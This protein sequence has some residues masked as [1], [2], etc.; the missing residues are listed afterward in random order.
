MALLVM[1]IR[2]M[3]KNKWLELSLLLGLVLSVGLIS[4]MPIYTDAILQ[5]MLVK[6]MENLQKSSGSY[7]G[8]V[9]MNGYTYSEKDPVQQLKQVDGFLE[10]DGL[11]YFKLPIRYLVK[12]RATETYPMILADPSRGDTKVNYAGEIVALEG[13]SEH[14]RLVDGRLPAKEPVDGVYEVLAFENTLNTFKTVIGTELLLGEEKSDTKPERKIKI[15]PVGVIDVKDPNDPYWY[16]VGAY[17]N[18]LFVDYSLFEKDFTTSKALPVRSATWY[19]VLDY[20]EMD[21]QAVSRFLAGSDRIENYLGTHLEPYNFKVPAYKTLTTYFD[22]EANLRKMLWSLNVPVIIMLAFYLF[23]VSNLITE[24]QKTEIAVLRSRG[25]SRFQVMLG[26]LIEGLLLG[27]LAYAI[28]PFFG[29]SLTKVL[30]SSNGF[31]EFVQ[32]S[33]LKVELNK[34]AYK[35]ALYAVCTSLVMTLIPAFLATRTSIVGHKQQLARQMR[36]SFWHKYGIDLVLIGVSI[37]GLRS[38]ERQRKDFIALGVDGAN[39]SVDP[40]LFLVP[41][42]FILGMGLLILRIYPW[43]VRFVYWL[44][45]KWWPPSLYSTLIQVGRSSTQYQFLMVFLIMTIATGLY[46]ASAARTLNKNTDDKIMY[47][48]GSDVVLETQWENDAPPPSDAGGPGGGEQSSQQ[49][50]A[51]TKKIQYTEPPFQPFTLLPGVEQAAKVFVKNGAGFTAGKERGAATLMGIETDQ[52]GK[53]AWLRDGLLDHHFNDYLNVMATNTSA[54]LIS[55]SLAEQ[56]GVKVGDELFAG[57][58][59]VEYRPFI[60]YG[61]VDYWPTFNP[62]PTGSETSSG[63]KKPVAPMLIIGHLS[64]IQNSLALE[65]YQVWIKLKK[66]AGRQE[67]YDAVVAKGYNVTSTT[68]TREQL[69]NARNDPFQLAINGVMTL[70]F[71]ISIVI[72]FFGFLLYWVLSLYGRILQL[73]ILRAMGISFLQLIGMLITEQLL[74]S[75]AAFLIGALTGTATSELFVKLFQVSFNPATQVPPFQVTFNPGDSLQLYVIVFMMIAIALVILS[76]LLS[77]I[78]IHQAVKLGED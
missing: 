41:A 20:S 74:T 4:S 42:F 40:L 32:R 77:R 59:G 2:K 16:N 68:D 63:N 14:V 51:S 3:Y 62:N 37:Y 48:N 52:F 31:L 33:A 26:Y 70:G 1:I 75:G 54:V 30:G 5:R 36:M 45:R 28:G 69:I 7:P 12:E 71:I 55:K 15:K 38:F 49:T 65:P 78:K 76:Y 66:D 53:A 43:F 73:G 6:D 25:A 61:I 47:A 29:M 27:G 24:R 23:M 39:F 56:K 22:R 67:F 10:T 57:W 46:S 18:S 64:Y 58:T 19:G 72:S 17:R 60:V 35:Y 11:P 21:L 44:G 8:V 13:L 34:E 50:V 9:Y